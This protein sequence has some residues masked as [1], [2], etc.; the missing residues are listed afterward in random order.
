MKIRQ[1]DFIYDYLFSLP[2]RATTQIQILTANSAEKLESN[3]T[4][5]I[6]YNQV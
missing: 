3:T 5:N 4:I 6:M 1:K 2:V